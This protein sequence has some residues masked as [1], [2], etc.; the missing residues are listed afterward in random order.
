M[1]ALW[2]RSWPAL[3]ICGVAFACR[4]SGYQSGRRQDAMFSPYICQMIL[5]DSCLEDSPQL[6]SRP[7]SGNLVCRGTRWVQKEGVAAVAALVFGRSIV[8]EPEL[9]PF[10]SQKYIP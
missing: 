9:P 3:K 6:I 1:C 10:D 5:G 4:L 8:S 2:R 7:P